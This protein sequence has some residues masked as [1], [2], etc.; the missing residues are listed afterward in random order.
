MTTTGDI[1]VT[2]DKLTPL[3]GVEEL[4]VPEQLMASC[5]A[6]TQKSVVNVLESRHAHTRRLAQS[7]IAHRETKPRFIE[8]SVISDAHT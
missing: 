2:L 8:M 3:I 1:W 7:R 6:S 4:G 5:T